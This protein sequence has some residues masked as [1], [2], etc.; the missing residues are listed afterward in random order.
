MNTIAAFTRSV[1]DQ[2]QDPMPRIRPVASAAG[3]TPTEEELK[4]AMSAHIVESTAIQREVKQLSPFCLFPSRTCP[5]DGSKLTAQGVEI[6]LIAGL[7]TMFPIYVCGQCGW[8]FTYVPRFPAGKILRLGKD[9]YENLSPADI[10]LQ[11]YVFVKHPDQ[12]KCHLSPSCELEGLRS[13]DLRVMDRDGSMHMIPAWQCRICNTLYVDMR[14]YE[15]YMQYLICRN[16]QYL[17][18]MISAG[19]DAVLTEEAFM[20]S[21]T[22]TRVYDGSAYPSDHLFVLNRGSKCPKCG[23]FRAQQKA[24]DIACRDGQTRR[25]AASVCMECGTAFLTKNQDRDLKIQFPLEYDCFDL[26]HL[27]ITKDEV[28]ADLPQKPRKG[29]MKPVTEPR[30]IAGQR[31]DAERKSASEWKAKAEPKSIKERKPAA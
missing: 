2:S 29:K 7:I 27:H 17:S 28:H 14:E 6:V 23:S 21:E 12:K 3:Y 16:P 13:I 26:E 31:P 9:L 30:Q 11:Y 24:V 25:I 1:Y 20:E 19:E 5:H 8:K 22:E 18:E 10:Q 15:A 4:N